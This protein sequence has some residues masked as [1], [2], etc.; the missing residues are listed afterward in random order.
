MV[1][2][3]MSLSVEGACVDEEIRINVTNLDGNPLI[4]ALVGVYYDGIL[5]A[6]LNT[7]ENGTVSFIPD[8]S[9]RYKII[10]SRYGYQNV[11][12]YIEVLVCSKE[13][14]IFEEVSLSVTEGENKTVEVR[15]ENV[16]NQRLGGLEV[17]S[18]LNWVE[19][20]LDETILDP[21]ESASIIF[22]MNS[23]GVIPGS[24]IVRVNIYSNDR[25]V[26]TKGYRIVVERKTGSIGL[27]PSIDIKFSIPD[28]VD[29][30]DKYSVE[31]MVE[32]TGDCELRNLTV[33][34]GSE[35]Q[36]ID[37]D[38]TERRTLS[39]VLT[40]PE[41]D[42][43]YSLCVGISGAKVHEEKEKEL[44]VRYSPLILKERMEGDKVYIT[45]K[46]DLDGIIRLEVVKGNDLVL[47]D[48]IET[49]K[50][51]MRVI[52]L[53]LGEY[54]V[55]A[56]LLVANKLVATKEI[57][58]GYIESPGIIDLD[59]LVLPLLA[60]L[61]FYLLVNI[62]RKIKNRSDKYVRTKL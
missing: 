13:E 30:G 21:E 1:S 45:A 39:F 26:G 60:I 42:G 19:M 14:L 24:Y 5:V 20:S 18:D 50:E 25:L 49:K 58:V 22:H 10:A 56:K 61:D 2:N 9:G 28:E 4:Y 29:V 62:I 43:I 23:T 3:N 34:L 16:A 40:A 51:T 46:S 48:L 55:N 33:R 59:L 36:V 6:D 8:K 41:Q 52:E 32:N 27:I 38:L 15:I 54:R 17:Y 35:A 12:G 47:I 31:V 44:Y 37:L 11:E 53:P 57:E 7:G